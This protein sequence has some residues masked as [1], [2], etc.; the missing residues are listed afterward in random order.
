[1]VMKT[2]S[3]DKQTTVYHVHAQKAHN[4]LSS[5]KGNL[6][7]KLLSEGQLTINKSTNSSMQKTIAN[8]LL[9]QGSVTVSLFD[10]IV[11]GFIQFVKPYVLQVLCLWSAQNAVFSRALW[12]VGKFVQWLVVEPS[13]GKKIWQSQSGS[14]SQF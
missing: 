4:S 6:D 12:T 13:L 11:R 1:M 9:Q 8:L 5:V 10:S 2:I 3:H 14:S 7:E